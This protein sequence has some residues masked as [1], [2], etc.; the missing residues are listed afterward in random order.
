MVIVIT[1]GNYANDEGQPFKIMEK[2]I[3]PALLS[4]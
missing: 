2:F 4:Q 3:L 1:G